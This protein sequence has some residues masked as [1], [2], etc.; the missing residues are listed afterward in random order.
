MEKAAA[1]DVEYSKFLG[2]DSEHTHLVK[3]ERDVYVDVLYVDV[4]F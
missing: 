4:L 1:L 2:G 3:G